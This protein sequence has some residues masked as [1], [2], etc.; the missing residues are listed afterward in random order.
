MSANLETLKRHRE[1]LDDASNSV[2]MQRGAYDTYRDRQ[3]AFDYAIAKLDEE[4]AQAERRARGE[5]SSCGYSPCMC[6]Q[7]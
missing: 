1:M 5:C 2:A 4:I 6:D 7:Q 3:N